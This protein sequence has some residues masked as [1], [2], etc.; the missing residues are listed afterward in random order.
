MKQWIK[1]I[2]C[3]HDYQPTGPDPEIRVKPG[4]TWLIH[5]RHKCVKCGKEIVMAEYICF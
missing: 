1:R 4:E 3:W 2:L 5:Q